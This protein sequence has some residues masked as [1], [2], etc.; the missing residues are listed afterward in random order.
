MT[1]SALLQQTLESSLTWNRARL[2]LLARVIL[3]LLQ[4]RSVNLARL[5]A[6]LSGKADYASRYKQLQR[7]MRWFELPFDELTRLLVKMC[8]VHPPFILVLDRTEWK[9]RGQ[10][11][12]VLVLCLWRNG[13]CCP[14]L[15]HVLAKAGC[16]SHLERVALLEEFERVFGFDKVKYLLGDREFHGKKFYQ[17]LQ[18]EGLKFRLRVRHDT[19]FTGS[20]AEVVRGR[21]L[22]RGLAIGVVVKFRGAKLLWG[23]RVWVWAKRLSAE[24][25]LIVVAPAGQKQSNLFVEYGERWRIEEMFE[26]VKTRG[27]CLE[28]TRICEPERLRRLIAIV[29]LAFIWAVR[30]GE[31]LIQK[32]PIKVNKMGRRIRSI[33]RVGLD[34]LTQIVSHLEESGRQA[35][36]VKVVQLMGGKPKIRLRL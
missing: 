26:S 27:F 36:F 16:T 30:V 21:E 17:Y 24:E 6:A 5:A 20:Q 18:K 19:A 31:I 12:N 8:G 3:A 35:K 2:K 9:I 13:V 33:F 23:N 10:S 22:V 34:E 14:I 25:T 7:W 32:K 29:A 1:D 11:I 28:G 15:W 4:V